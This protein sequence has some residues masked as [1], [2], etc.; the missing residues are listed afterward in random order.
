[1]LVNNQSIKKLDPGEKS[2]PDLLV[3][4][5]NTPFLVIFFCRLPS[6][7]DHNCY[8]NHKRLQGLFPQTF[9]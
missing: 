8:A 9:Q 3:F 4:F 6:G 5:N 1:M 7:I 2:Q